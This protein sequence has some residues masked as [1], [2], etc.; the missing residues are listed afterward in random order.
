M[1][2]VQKKEDKQHKSFIDLN[3]DL[4]DFFKSTLKTVKE[5]NEFKLVIKN[6]LEDKIANDDITVAQ[7]IGLYKAVYNETTLATDSIIS[8]FKPT[9][10]SNSPIANA[11]SNRSNDDI[12]ERQISDYTS[13][14]LKGLDKLR[15]LLEFMKNSEEK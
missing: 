10:N 1:D 8:L 5:E 6:A 9:P 12:N 3:A 13:D 7:L 11:M 4:F 14:E 15:R 2:E